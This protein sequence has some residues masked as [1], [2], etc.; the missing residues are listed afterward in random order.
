MILLGKVGTRGRLLNVSKIVQKTAKRQSGH[1]VMEIKPSNY[2]WKYLKNAAHFWFLL[3]AVPMSVI[4]TIINIR[5]N[6][7]LTEIPEG[8]EPRHWEYY[9]HPVSRFLAKYFY[10]PMEL[11]HEMFMSFADLTSE[12]QIM[13]DIKNNV[14]RVMRFHND[15][16]S[17]YFRPFFGEYYRIGRDESMYGVN[18]MSS[19]EGHFYDYAHDPAITQVPVEGYKPEE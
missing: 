5:A 19:A 16:R 15:H 11:E 13:Q 2:E 6:P 17:R 12:N 3:G 14:E 9:K 1:N 4:A 18:F 10:V 8:Y 7:E